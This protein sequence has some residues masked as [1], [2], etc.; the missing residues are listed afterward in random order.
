MSAKQVKVR[1]HPHSHHIVVRGSTYK[2][3]LHD[4]YQKLQINP[5]TAVQLVFESN[6]Q[7]I[8]DENFNNLTRDEEVVLQR[9]D[10]ENTTPGKKKILLIFHQIICIF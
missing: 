5:E 7:I 9:K 3:L 1:L 8:N 10:H 6:H 4:C 2:E